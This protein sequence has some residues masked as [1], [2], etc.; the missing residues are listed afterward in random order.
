MALRY[1]S[2]VPTLPIIS[3]IFHLTL[4][5]NSGVAFGLFRGYGLVVTLATVFLLGGIFWTTL[6]GQTSAN[7]KLLFLAFGLMLGGAAGNLLDR[8]RY[9]GVVDFLDF[10]IW[11]VFN[12]AD[13]CITIGAALMAWFLWKRH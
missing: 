7:R 11:P 10:R 9:G 5:V 1:L 8:L 4:V 12:L 6:R 2:D 13:S 3:G